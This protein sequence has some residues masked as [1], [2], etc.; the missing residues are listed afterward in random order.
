LRVHESEA[1]SFEELS[2]RTSIKT[3]RG[4]LK[5]EKG[6][7]GKVALLSRGSSC[8]LVADLIIPDVHSFHSSIQRGG[9]I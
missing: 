7:N 8:S 9:G 1:I 2:T 5:V 6:P 4:E 3:K